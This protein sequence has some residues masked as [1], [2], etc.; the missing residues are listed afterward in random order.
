MR[1]TL[2][3]YTC[4]SAILKELPKHSHRRWSTL[5]PTMDAKYIIFSYVLLAAFSIGMYPIET[6]PLFIPM[7]L[8]PVFGCDMVF[9]C[10]I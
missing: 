7:V 8:H 10:Q 4:V 9:S 6:A 5:R 3:S 2:E 1:S